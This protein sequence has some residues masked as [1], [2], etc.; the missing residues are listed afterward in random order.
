MLK[1]RD[2]S[3][4]FCKGLCTTSVNAAELAADVIAAAAAAVA[5]GDD[6]DAATTGAWSGDTAA[7]A[8]GDT[9]YTSDTGDTGDASDPTGEDACNADA[10]L[11]SVALGGTGGGVDETRGGSAGFTGTGCTD[12]C[13]LTASKPWSD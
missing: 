7:T 4:Y 1:L 6:G 10:E 13:F 12:G 9:G 5:A 3:R 8:A 11:D 2:D